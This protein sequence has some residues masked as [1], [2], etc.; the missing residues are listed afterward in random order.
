[1]APKRKLANTDSDAAGSPAS[2][3]SQQQ[4]DRAS[5]HVHERQQQLQQEQDEQEQRQDGPSTQQQ[6]QPPPTPP[7]QQWQAS[8]EGSAPEPVPLASVENYPRK[9]ISI[10]VTSTL[11]QILPFAPRPRTLKCSSRTFCDHLLTR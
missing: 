6:K 11:S 8:E 10:A 5:E 7:Q 3:V 2:L 4:H 1:M 9:R